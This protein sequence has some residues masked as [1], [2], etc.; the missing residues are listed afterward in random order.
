MI[1]W[2]GPKKMKFTPA[3]CRETINRKICENEVSSNITQLTIMSM[4]E[5]EDFLHFFPKGFVILTGARI[6]LPEAKANIKA[7]SMFRIQAP[8]GN[9]AR[10]IQQNQ[11]KSERLNSYD[12]FA[13]I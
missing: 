4:Q 6:P 12:V 2:L 10:A 3:H 13:V 9:G 11:V 7:G 1:Q 8:Y 5:P